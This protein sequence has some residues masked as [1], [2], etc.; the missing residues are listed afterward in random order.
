VA[1]AGGGI[2]NAGTLIVTAS[3]I[4]DNSGA[5][6]GGIHNAANATVELR[7]VLVALNAASRGP[8]LA[9]AYTSLG[10]NLVGQT[11]GNTG[12][13]SGFNIV[14]RDRAGD[15]ETP[16][17]PKLAPLAN[18]GGPTPT[19]A[20]LPLSPAIS[21][22]DDALLGWP[23]HLT[24]DQR[25]APRRYG[26]HVDAGAH[27][28]FPPLP[29]TVTAL[30][31]DSLMNNPITGSV[32]A[33]LRARVNPNGYPTLAWFEFG[34]GTN[35]SS[36]VPIRLTGFADQ[37]VNTQVAGLVPGV[38]YYFRAAASNEVGITFGPG[39]SLTSPA[40]VFQTA[41]DRNGDGVVDANEITCV[42]S[43][44]WRFVP[45]TIT[46]LTSPSNTVWHFDLDT[47]TNL[48][49]MVLATADVSAPTER[50]EKLGPAALSYRV[51]D[52]AATNH[53]ARFYQLRWP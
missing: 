11:N 15:G 32:E 6:G 17:D 23:F 8:D 50:W 52:P 3:T 24:T 49:L 7:S 25:G 13:I 37:L 45:P 34:P 33:R 42:L 12:F 14:T 40:S 31:P 19:R 28:L 27:E 36:T 10:H 22:G 18:N 43:N 16:L 4:S 2:L 9:G 35:R 38:T 48:S 47:L 39:Q 30:P 51:V 29:P 21:T 1:G 46:S 20:L 26:L 53:P 44:H 5:S 41:G